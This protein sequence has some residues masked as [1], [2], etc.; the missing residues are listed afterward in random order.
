MNDGFPQFICRTCKDMLDVAKQFRDRCKES[1]ELLRTIKYQNELDEKFA[2]EYLEDSPDSNGGECENEIIR[3]VPLVFAINGMVLCF[4][5]KSI[6]NGDLNVGNPI[7]ESSTEYLVD[8]QPPLATNTPSKPLNHEC[9]E[10]GKIVQTARKLKYHMQMHITVKPYSCPQ[11]KQAFRTNIN[12]Q[13]HMTKHADD[14]PFMCEVG[15]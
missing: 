10:C 3:Y 5:M 7:D 4:K 13:V 14:R 15:K 12:L 11:C 1:D 2:T 8:T 6:S 9:P